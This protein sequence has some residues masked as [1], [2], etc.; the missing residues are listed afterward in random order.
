M[1]FRRKCWEMVM[2]GIVSKNTEIDNVTRYGY[3]F[4][5]IENRAISEISL[6]YIYNARKTI[7][8]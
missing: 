1:Q 7:S 4:V 3:K 8:N 2:L 6:V 5:F